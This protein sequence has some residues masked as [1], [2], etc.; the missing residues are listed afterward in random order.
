MKNMENGRSGWL[1]NGDSGESEQKLGCVKLRKL[2]TLSQKCVVLPPREKEMIIERTEKIRII[3]I[4]LGEP[5]APHSINGVFYRLLETLWITVQGIA[6][7][8]D[9]ENH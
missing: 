1:R 9:H 7:E 8:Q 2:L 5:V 6:R 3:T 4:Y